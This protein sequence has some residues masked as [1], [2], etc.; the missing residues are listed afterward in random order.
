MLSI[1]SKDGLFA[2]ALNRAGFAIC[3][4]GTTKTKNLLGWFAPCGGHRH[5]RVQR[6][7]TIKTGTA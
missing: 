6:Q 2:F 4:Q 7:I 3:A 1:K 5:D